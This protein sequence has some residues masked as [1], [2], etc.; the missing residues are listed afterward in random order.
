MTLFT[1]EMRRNP[2]PVYAQLRGGGSGVVHWP[3]SWR[4]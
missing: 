1:D 2:Y 4:A 3:I